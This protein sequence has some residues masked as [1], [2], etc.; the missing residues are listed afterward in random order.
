[1][2]SK[3]HSELKP[4][5]WWQDLQTL[6]NDKKAYLQNSMP[7]IKE[8]ITTQSQW[9]V[10]A[11]PKQRACQ[12]YSDFFANR[13]DRSIVSFDHFSAPVPAVEYLMRC[14]INHQRLFIYPAS[15]PAKE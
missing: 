3:Y 4:Y 13:A 5:R 14:T 15:A 12:Q 8:G 7:A 11:V 9:I 1:M 10:K 2:F 6:L